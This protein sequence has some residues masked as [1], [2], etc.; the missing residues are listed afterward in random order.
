[1]SRNQRHVSVFL[2]VF[3]AVILKIQ[4]QNIRVIYQ[5]Q[6]DQSERLI[7]KADAE[8]RDHR[9]ALD[10]IQNT[11]SG[12]RRDG[13]LAASAD[14]INTDSV[15]VHVKMYAGPQFQWVELRL[16]TIAQDW[17]TE[18]HWKNGMLDHEKLNPDQYQSMISN[19]MRFAENHG[20]PFAEIK[21][22]SI[23]ISD[24]GVSAALVLN[25]NRLFVMDTL[26]IRGDAKVSK[27]FLAGYLGLEKDE[28]YNESLIS[29]MNSK[30]RK[31]P[32][33]DSRMNNRVYF[34]GNRVHVVLELKEKRTDQ[35]DG[36][37]GFAPNST[38]DNKLLITGEV[39]MDLKN[40]LRRGIGY[41]MHWKS[42]QQRSQELKLG[43][44]VPYIFQK[45][46]G[47]D[48]RLEYLK[49]DTLFFKL[50]STAG[51]RYFFGGTNYLQFYYQNNYTSLIS[52]DTNQIRVTKS[53][54]SSNPV[55][56]RSYGIELS[57][58]KVDYINNPRRG[59]Q[60]SL[61]GNIGTRT[62]QKD[63]RISQLKFTESS[64]SYFTLYDSIKLNTTQGMLEYTA[65]FFI[66]V[67]KQ[68]A[69]VPSVSGKYL[70]AQ[71]IF[72]NDLYR[73]GGMKSLR[74][75]NENS[76]LA[77]SFTIGTLEY[78]YL[79]SENSYFQLF[80]NGARTFN[81]SGNSVKS[82]WPLGFGAGVNLEVKSGILSLAYA[83][84]REQGNP[85][86]IS[87]AKIH[88][89]IINYL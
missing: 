68:S 30:L 72:L 40:I 46:V 52:V 8:F 48:V 29:K 19:L 73:Y 60:L 66:P 17:L 65:N 67:F 5:T 42:F 84:G 86:K 56:V 31:L 35:L 43:S 47:V 74:G 36:I 87:N 88:F 75:F 58:N 32:F 39:N 10:Y 3:C 50:Q 76:L 16:N 55:K 54:P 62:I 23:E 69:I 27:N 13:Y 70:L 12:W 9:S 51:V 78:R 22:D 61:N 85:I 14:S 83:L 26:E 45:P 49:Y 44:T 41:S 37:V 71:K 6:D 89:G 1:M 38:T 79:F 81:A 57:L 11:I 15:S 2:L 59:I 64:G 18:L 34:I 25:K 4:A 53:L 24:A 28:P 21:L 80:F 7:K 20:Y 77:S 82:D 33:L 63:A